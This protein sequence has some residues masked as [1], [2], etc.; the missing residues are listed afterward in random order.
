MSTNDFNL[1]VDFGLFFLGGEVSE[2]GTNR[3]CTDYG[4]PSALGVP[5]REPKTL[6]ENTQIPTSQSPTSLPFVTLRERLGLT[7]SS[8]FAT[9]SRRV[10][11]MSM[12]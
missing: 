10:S 6:V 4:F 9:L 5:L 12:H 2:Y 3:S 8:A 11:R 1:V 7:A